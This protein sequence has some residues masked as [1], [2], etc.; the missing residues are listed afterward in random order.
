MPAKRGGVKGAKKPVTLT[1]AIVEEALKTREIKTQTIQEICETV[2]RMME[3]EFREIDRIEEADAAVDSTWDDIRRQEEA[4]RGQMVE[5]KEDNSERFRNRLTKQRETL[6]IKREVMTLKGYGFSDDQVALV[7]GMALETLKK[8]HG[9]ELKKGAL[10]QN[11]AVL[12]NLYSIATDPG[13]RGSTQAAIFWAKARAGW[14]ETNRTE[15][16]GADGKP[17][18]MEVSQAKVLDSSKLSAEHREKLREVLEAAIAQESMMP[19]EE[20]SAVEEEEGAEFFEG[21][22]DGDDE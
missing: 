6:R 10:I 5:W 4:I 3:P 12:K 18:K 9:D 7:M 22:D 15:V 8:H 19:P 21:D 14:T 2:D 17:L 20:K 1:D 13:H 11:A 16:T